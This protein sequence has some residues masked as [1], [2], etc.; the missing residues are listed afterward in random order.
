[1]V[2]IG[3][4]EAQNELSALLDRVEK[5]EQIVITREGKAV[6]RLVPETGMVDPATQQAAHE[7]LMRIRARAADVIGPKITWEE[8]NA[9]RDEGRK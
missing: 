6:A 8:M 7:A 4:F 9:W 2:E 3:A 1:M 5:G